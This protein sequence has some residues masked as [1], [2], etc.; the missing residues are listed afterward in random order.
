M[1]LAERARLLTAESDQMVEGLVRALWDR[2]PGYEISALDRAE[3]IATIKASVHTVMTCLA[4]DR[5]PQEDELAPARTLG[6]RRAIQGVPVESVI[7]SWQRAERVFVERLLAGARSLSP[8]EV[9]ETQR[10]VGQLVDRMAE[11]ATTAYRDLSGDVQEQFGQVSSDIVSSLAGAHPLEST[12]LDRRARLIGAEPQLPHRVLA[13]GTSGV[14]GLALA[15][16]T[17]QVAEVLRPHA[18]GRMLA[19]SHQGWQ[20]LVV[21][22][23]DDVLA[24]ISRAVHHGGLPADL[25]AGLGEPRARLAEAA[26]SLHE[27][28]SALQVAIILGRR[29]ARF[30]E[31][32]PEVFLRESPLSARTMMTSVLGP[33]EQRD[34]IE[35]LRTFLTSG[36]SVR[37][38][39]RRMHVHE[40]T[41]AY[42]VKKI[43]EAMGVP[44][45][46][47]LVRPDILMA[48]RAR[49]MFE[50][51]VGQDRR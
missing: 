14:D 47:E 1:D 20:L 42:R 8:A 7:W 50:H 16:A 12:E 17:R 48:L 40:N 2:V 5:A 18:A 35:T 43:V 33:L 44:G 32:V 37:A 41:V 45:V 3:L 9:H 25:F 28:I 23:A 13:L 27:A 38:T 49:E 4:E 10:R 24:V 34:L 11:A 29:L 21:S 36:L 51:P 15:K 39:A 46:N 30:A 6:E 22:E 19:G 31:V 26:G